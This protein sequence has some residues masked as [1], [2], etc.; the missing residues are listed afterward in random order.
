MRKHPEDAVDRRREHRARRVEEAHARAAYAREL[1]EVNLDPMVTIGEDGKITDVNKAAEEVTGVSRDELIGSDFSTYFTEPD[2]ARAGYRQVF[3][4]GLV[5]DYPLAVR[6]SSGRVT[7]VLYNAT[8]YRD[9]AG[10]V[11][12]VLAVARDITAHKR[13]EE[14]ERLAEMEA[15]K[16]DFYRRTILAATGGKLVIT[17]S[18]E[19]ERIAGPPDAV[20]EL[21]SAD[22]LRLVRYDVAE[23]AQ[24]IGMDAVCI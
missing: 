24:S 8:V 11:I 3:S 18:E 12:G 13:V 5:R 6:H 23:T 9:T 10:N 19:I 14:M 4:K 21:T 16:L 1:I 2:K 20:W 7:E 22:Q 17:E 15:H